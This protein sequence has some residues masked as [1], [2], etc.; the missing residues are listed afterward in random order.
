MNPQHMHN[1]S[2][3]EQIN[4]IV[5]MYVCMC[6]CVNAYATGSQAMNQSTQH[7]ACMYVCTETKCPLDMPVQFGSG[8]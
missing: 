2:S 4:N 7:C 8:A 5:C 6:V 3:S 1:H